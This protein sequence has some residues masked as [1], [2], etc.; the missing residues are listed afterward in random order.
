VYKRQAGYLGKDGYIRIKINNKG[1]TA[2]RLVYIYHYGDIPN[3]LQIDHINGIRDDN[4]IENLRLVT[5]Q[6]NQWNQTKAKGYYWHKRNKTYLARIVI[7]GK[8]KHI[9][10]FDNEDDARNAYIMAKV[11]LHKIQNRMRVG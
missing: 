11:D 7:D 2:H 3:D 8:L 5:H 9:G 4:R 6:E 10:S 1:Y